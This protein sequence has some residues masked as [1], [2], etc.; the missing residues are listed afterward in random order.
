MSSSILI[1]THLMIKNIIPSDDDDF[2]IKSA[3]IKNGGCT[4]HHAIFQQSFWYI[5]EQKLCLVPMSVK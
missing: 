3:Q 1:L 4:E 5:L 2:Q